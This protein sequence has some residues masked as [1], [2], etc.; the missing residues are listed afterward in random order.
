VIARVNLVYG[1]PRWGGGSF[2]EEVIRTVQSGKPYPLF[3]DQRRSF[4]SV[5]NLAACLWEI[6]TEDFS[7]ILHLGGAE[8]ADR[9]AF[10]AKLA[11]RTALDSALLIPSSTEAAPMGVRYPRDNTFDLTLVQRVLKTPLL[12]LDAG[13]ALEYP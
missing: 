11:R 3:A 12:D 8:S 5:Q 6:A 7:G 4:I 1:R 2:S 13:L 9:V 10:A